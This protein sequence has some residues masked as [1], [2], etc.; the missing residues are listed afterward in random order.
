MTD[1]KGK[2]FGGD[3]YVGYRSPPKSSQFVKGRSG[4]PRGRPRRPKTVSANVFGDNEFDT[5]L[6][7]EMG[8]LV[9]TREGETI[10]KIPLVRVATRAIGLKAAKGD[11]KAYIALTAKRAAVENR[12][13]AQQEEFLRAVTEYKQE[14]TQE[15]MRRKRNGASEP[16]I[17]PHPDDI[18]FDPTTGAVR[19]NGPVTLDQKM[20]QDL[21]VSTWPAVEREMRN[22]ARSVTKEPWFLRQHAELTRQFETVVRLVTKR[23]SRTNSWELATLEERMDHLRRCHWP[24][25]S[26]NFPPEFVQSECCFKSIFRPWLGIEPTEE[27]Q[28]AFVT[29]ALE[30]FLRQQ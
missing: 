24:T 17:I 11:V 27:E 26:K 7:E 20:A 16:E 10:E 3:E 8:R 9:T 12:R 25:I 29:Q 21:V 5:M 6:L 28:Q 18:D 4:N 30:V 19:F 1:T 2:A 13:R 15:L 22:S 14:A 23:A